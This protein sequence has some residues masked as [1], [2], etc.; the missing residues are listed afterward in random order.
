[1]L[2]LILAALLLAWR[3]AKHERGL[4]DWE[5]GIRSVLR[6][7]NKSGPSAESVVDSGP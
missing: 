1:M 3:G 5:Y 4:A 7:F 2:G 6:S